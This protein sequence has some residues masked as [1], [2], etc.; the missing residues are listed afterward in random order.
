MVFLQNVPAQTVSWPNDPVQVRRPE[1]GIGPS[2][3]IEDRMMQMMMM[4]ALTMTLVWGKKVR[5]TVTRHLRLSPSHLNHSPK[6]TGIMMGMLVSMTMIIDHDDHEHDD[7]K[8]DL[9]TM[10]TMMEEDA[11]TDSLS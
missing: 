2:D 1:G 9:M 6:H 4:M 11:D 8:H 3:D 7:H 5:Y 10:I